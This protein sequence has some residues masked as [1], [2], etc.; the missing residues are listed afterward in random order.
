[1]NSRVTAALALLLIAGSAMAQPPAG[2]PPLRGPDATNN[3][4][5]VGD[6]GFDGAP[7]ERQKRWMGDRG[8]P[9]PE[10][11]AVIEGLKQES[12]PANLRLSAEQEKQVKTIAEGFRA[13]TLAFRDKVRGQRGEGMEPPADKSERDATRSRMEEMRAQ[14]PKPADAQTKMWAVLSPEQQ[15]FLQPELDRVKADVESRRM[16]QVGEQRQRRRGPG[17]EGSPN[18]PGGPGAFG[19]GGERG[20]R[21]MQ[22]LRALSPEQREQVLSKLEAELNKVDGGGQAQ[23]AA[24][25]NDQQ[26]GGNQPLPPR[27]LRVRPGGGNDAPPPPPAPKQPE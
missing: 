5:P 10:Y 23:G 6:Q 21:L 1:M 13:E 4:P 2:G 19:A 17:G 18:G 11:V 26:Q 16:D 15:K 8:I 3:R 22:R 9:M 14:A 24:Q 12:T 27:R 7:I 25:P 20:M